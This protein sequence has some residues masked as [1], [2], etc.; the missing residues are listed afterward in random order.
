M[1]HPTAPVAA[2][3]A[4]VTGLAWSFIVLAGFAS[5][6]SV[7]QNIMIALMFPMEEMRAS[8]R[9]SE[10]TPPMPAMFRFMFEYFQYVVAG[11]LLLSVGTLIS[12]I[13]LLKRKNWARLIFVVIMA[14]GIVWNLA[15]L[16]MPFLMSS[17][18]PE[19]PAPAHSDF[20]DN[21]K[22]MWNIMMGFTVVMCLAFAALF[23]WIIK[24]LLAADI[25]REFVGTS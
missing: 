22:L 24:R 4:F 19:M 25:R 15:S 6:I 10:T 12:A 1:N 5:V 9:E 16:A 21:F 13:G 2:R 8:V 18:M 11:F 23:A 7:L 20:H 14:L 17:M 3:S